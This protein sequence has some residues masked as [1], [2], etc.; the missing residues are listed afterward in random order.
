MFEQTLLPCSRMILGLSRRE[1]DWNRLKGGIEQLIWQAELLDTGRHRRLQMNL[2]LHFFGVLQMK[3]HLKTY[4]HQKI[5]E[6]KWQ[7]A[8][9]HQ[10]FSDATFYG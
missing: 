2:P 9:A 5:K 7:M 1:R 10:S 4:F 6:R 3:E 8:A